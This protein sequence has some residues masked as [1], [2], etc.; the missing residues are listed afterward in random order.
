MRAYTCPSCSVVVTESE[1]AWDMLTGS[2]LCPKC[3]SVVQR[4]HRENGHV[5]PSVGAVKGGNKS[6]V[7]V[8]K[9]NNAGGYRALDGRQNVG[10]HSPQKG[11]ARAGAT[12]SLTLNR[13]QRWTLTIAVPIAAYIFGAGVLELPGWQDLGMMDPEEVGKWLALLGVIV[14]FQLWIWRD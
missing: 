10:N 11:S 6:R 14:S 1:K 4:G 2:G 9:S 7:D 8:S 3:G 5:S 13:A 12:S